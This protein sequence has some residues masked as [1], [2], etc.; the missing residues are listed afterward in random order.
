MAP[1]HGYNVAEQ[2]PS[3][4][5]L[6]LPLYP[7]IH[8]LDQP[9]PEIH[10]SPSPISDFNRDFIPFLLNLDLYLASKKFS[11]DEAAISRI[12]LRTS[13]STAA[14]AVRFTTATDTVSLSV[15]YPRQ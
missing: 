8:P 14:A 7:R 5:Q 10:V 6:P 11:E 4:S 13:I 1:F 2:P 9:P 3:A 15:L 12:S